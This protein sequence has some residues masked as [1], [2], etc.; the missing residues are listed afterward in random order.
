MWS[1]FIR[2]GMHYESTTRFLLVTVKLG[3]SCEKHTRT[4]F[5]NVF[6]IKEV[7]PVP[8]NSGMQLDPLQI[9]SNTMKYLKHQTEETNASCWL[10]ADQIT[11]GRRYLLCL[12]PERER[13]ETLELASTQLI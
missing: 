4:V 1:T 13:A 11:K 7:M 12:C 9:E 8:R 3:F 10:C 6:M 2:I 5:D